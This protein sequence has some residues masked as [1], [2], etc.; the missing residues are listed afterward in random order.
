MD[1]LPLRPDSWSL[2]TH[3]R[4][5]DRKL[6]TE[7]EVRRWRVYNK[8]D[9]SLNVYSSRSE[10]ERVEKLKEEPVPNQQEEAERERERENY[11]NRQEM[12]E[13]VQ[14]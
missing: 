8:A 12:K 5:M 7:G 2:S 4:D 10:A 11:T 6:N 14:Q 3:R 9:K 13:K 1:A